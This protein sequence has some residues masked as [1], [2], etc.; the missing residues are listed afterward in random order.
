MKLHNKI[1]LGLVLGAAAGITANQVAKDAAWLTWANNNVMNPVGQ[2]FLRMLIMTVIPLV[3]SSLTL[4]VAGLG[5]IRRIGKVGGKAILYFILSTTLSATI[6][7]FLVNL[8]RPGD[9]LDPGIQQE[10]LPEA[11][12]VDEGPLVLVETKRDLRNMDLPF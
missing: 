9:G 4:G 1:I 7:L 6:G 3:F 5:D 8:V 2:V 12:V 10:L 11:V